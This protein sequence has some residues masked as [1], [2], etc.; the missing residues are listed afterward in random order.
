MDRK[1]ESLCSR[2]QEGKRKAEG[3]ETM[4]DGFSAILTDDTLKILKH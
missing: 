4:I 3:L 2:L 1:F